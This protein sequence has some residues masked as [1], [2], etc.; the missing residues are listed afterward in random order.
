[1]TIIS[2]NKVLFKLSTM[3]QFIGVYKPF[4]LDNLFKAQDLNMYMNN[5][6]VNN[7]ADSHIDMQ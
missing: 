3:Y 2:I 7:S 4:A 5:E 6:F 1:M